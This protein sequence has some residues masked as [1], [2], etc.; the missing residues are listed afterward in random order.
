MGNR[1]RVEEYKKLRED[2]E[3]IDVYS[4][5]DPKK[6]PPS[7]HSN[8]PLIPVN[9]F[10]D[11]DDDEFK[12]V[13]STSEE[14]HVKKN[15]LTLTIDEIIK[16]HE[17]YTEVLQK[18]ELDKRIKEQKEKNKAVFNPKIILWIAIGVIIVVAVIILSLVMAGVI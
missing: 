10:N 18:Q 16:Q 8:V 14:D 5:D 13:S 4:F 15:T 12:I 2:I 17:A 3:N 11:E 6:M 9:D 7:S 1:T